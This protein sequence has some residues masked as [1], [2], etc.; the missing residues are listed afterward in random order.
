MRQLIESDKKICATFLLKFSKFSVVDLDAAIDKESSVVNDYIQ[1]AATLIAT[2]L[3]LSYE[4][5]NSKANIISVI[6]SYAARGTVKQY[7]CN[8][9]KEAPIADEAAVPLEPNEPVLNEN[10][11]V[12]LIAIN[13]GG[14]LKA[15]YFV[16]CLS[17][18]CWKVF[19]EI[20][21]NE[22]LHKVF[23]AS[24]SQR[25]LFCKIM[26]NIL[27]TQDYNYIVFGKDMCSNG[28]DREYQIIRCMFN[29]FM[30]NHEKI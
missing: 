15:T 7:K 29:C 16:F 13:R 17:I 3:T 8:N 22:I 1:T 26:D 30:K 10:G 28:H 9:C 24:D 20:R 12:F 2:Q 4:P 27:Y 14:L 19:E 11:L 18:M 5:T 23:I 6:S 21:I 25:K